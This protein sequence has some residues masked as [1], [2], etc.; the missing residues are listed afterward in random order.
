MNFIIS[1]LFGWVLGLSLPVMIAIG[2]AYVLWAAPVT[3]SWLRQP[4]LVALTASGCW[5]GMTVITQSAVSEAVRHERAAVAAAVAAEQKRRA[6]AT[7]AAIDA[8]NAQAEST[9]HEN[10]ALQEK[11]TAY[12][13]DLATQARATPAVAAGACLAS[14]ADFGRVSDLL[15]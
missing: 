6:D 5:L 4:A 3:W 7:D 11:V 15:R 14:P 9:A 2:S 13:A 8:A 12:E 1:W 10:A